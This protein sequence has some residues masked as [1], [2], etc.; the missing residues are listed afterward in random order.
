MSYTI[1]ESQYREASYRGVPFCVLDS[2][3]AGGRRVV[4]YEYPKQD[5]PYTQDLGRK[6]N[7]FTVEAFVLGDDHIEQAND[8]EAALNEGGSGTLILPFR[9]N[10][11][12]ICTEW[13]RSESLEAMGRTS[14]TLTFCEFGEFRTPFTDVAT[15]SNFLNSVRDAV[16]QISDDFTDAIS[17]FDGNALVR[18]ATNNVLF[19]IAD[20][21]DNLVSNFTNTAVQEILSFSDFVDNLRDNPSIYFSSLSLPVFLNGILDAISNNALDTRG[22]FNTLTEL[23]DFSSYDGLNNLSTV[24]N[25]Q[26]FS[27]EVY[28]NNLFLSMAGIQAAS[29]YSKNEYTNSAEAI[30]DLNLVTELIES[31]MQLAGDSGYDVIYQQLCKVLADLRCDAQQRILNLPSRSVRTLT[32]SLPSLVVA[33]KLYGDIDRESELINLNCVANP[34]FMPTQVQA[35]NG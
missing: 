6:Q 2:E 34:M 16:R 19:D 30:E 4:K 18:E 33:Y 25:L 31:Q 10:Q 27:N 28:I 9:D 23:K 8:L 14:F 35:L 29:I 20:E 12:V 22:V 5:I 24:S 32:K 26:A 17:Y 7:E 11:T 13:R 21:L 15:Q 1:D 3:V